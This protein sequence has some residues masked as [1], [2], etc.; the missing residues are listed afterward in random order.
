MNIRLKNIS[1]N[2]TIFFLLFLFIT[3]KDKV[4]LGASTALNVWSK[5]IFP[6]LFPTFI[7]VDLLL[8]SSLFKV[9][10]RLL[11]NFFAKIFKTSKYSAFIFV[12][13]IIAG[14]PTNA[15]IL[16]K[17][18]DDGVLEREQIAKILG[19]TYFFNPFFILTFTNFK[20]LII[21]WLSNFLTGI[22]M[23][24]KN[25]LKED[26]NYSRKVNFNLSDSISN[27]MNIVLNILGT[28]TIFMVISYSIP[29][30][31][32]FINVII[33]SM[34]ELTNGL[35]KINLYFKN[36]YFY[37]FSL[38]IGGLSILMQIKS[39]MKDTL[40]DYKYILKTRIITVIISLII[41]WLT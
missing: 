36:D 15:K 35:F 13:S 33:T 17:M 12:V 38:G 21:F 9:V 16:K 31:N 5:N 23:R 29:F 18:Y 39:I 8:A 7:L 1:K 25:V 40:I 30:F 11:G 10:T 6:I 41:C 24:N 37:L 22:I 27:N 3:C 4:I 28:V 19:F 14:T 2:I 20:V 32:P 34:L 26:Y